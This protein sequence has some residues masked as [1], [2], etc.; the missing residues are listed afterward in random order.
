MV[1]EDARER[2]LVLGLELVVELLF[3]ALGDLAADRLRI[4]SRG[5]PLG[6][7]QDQSEVLHVGAHGG[8][9][10]RVLDLDRD[11]P[12]VLEPGPVDLADRGGRDRLLV[13]AL[14]HLVDRIVE[15]VLDHLAHLLEGD[16]RRRVA[17]RCRAFAGTRRGT[18][19]ARGRRRGT[20]SPARAS[21][22]RPSSSPARPRSARP[23]LSGVVRAPRRA[24][25]CCAPRLPRGCPPDG[26]PG[27][28]Q[29]PRSWPCA[30]RARWGSCLSPLLVRMLAGRSGLPR[31]R[32]PAARYSWVT[33][34]PGTMSSDPSGHRTHA[35]WPPS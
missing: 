32:R 35:L 6:E 26:S 21:S 28:L 18:P 30:P 11:I 5:D 12:A 4:H 23:P 17:Q 8:G 1:P 34:E 20:T 16:R 9:D 24:A 19:R 25:P 27:L 14:E 2:P 33:R 31:R 29:A 7:A 13:E 3:D 15:L 10:A 22:P